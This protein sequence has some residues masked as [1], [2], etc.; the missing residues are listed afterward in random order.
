MSD[1]ETYRRDVRALARMWGVQASYTSAWGERVEQHPD[2]VVG[3]LGALG[4]D[5]ARP[6]SAADAVQARRASV[7]TRLLEPVSV[8]WGGRLE[9]VALR[10]A[11]RRRW[12]DPVTVTV[13]PEDDLGDEI[14]IR[15]HAV[16]DGAPTEGGMVA[17]SART[18]LELP[19]GYHRIAVEA[20]GEGAEGLLLAAPRRAP[21]PRG[22]HWGAFA[23]VYGL[24]GPQD[25]GVG[26]YTDLERL[27]AWLRSHGGEVMATVPMLAAFLDEPF[28]PSPYSP[29]SRLF[30]NELYV[31]VSRAPGSERNPEARRRIE[32]QRAWVDDLRRAEVVDARAVMSATREI[33]EPLAEACFR[34]GSPSMDR[35][36]AER[37]EV[38]DYARFRAEGDRRRTWWGDW[39]EAARRGDL[40]G[41]ARDDPAGRYHLFAQWVA[42]EQIAGMAARSRAEGGE[43]YLDL[44]LGVNGAGFDVWRHRDVFATGASAGSPPDPFFTGGQDWGFPPLHPERLRE[45]G[46]AYQIACLRHLLRSA[47][48]LR[49]DHV[50]SLHRLWWVPQG[51]EAT[52]GAYV[53]YPHDEWY[54]LVCLEAARADAVVVGEDLGTVPEEV[55]R[56]MRRHGLLSSYVLQY[57]AGAEDD[58]SSPREAPET[59]LASINTHDMP[60]WAGFWRGEDL[61]IARERGWMDDEEAVDARRARARVL[62]AMARLA[63]EGATGEPDMA[64]VLRRLLRHLAAGPASI[65]VATL[66]DLWLDPRPVNVPGTTDLPNWLVRLDRTLADI[67]DDQVL[68]EV[69]D[70]IHAARKETA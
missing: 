40:P 49:L 19:I 60:P 61:E 54:A 70:E 15:A 6:G 29:A 31:D 68:A 56:A 55:R 35:F 42:H 59:S 43:V 65:V 28:E 17:A 27:H 32:E 9:H 46:Y 39:P 22:R 4:V 30:W 5:A 13:R 8:A 21:S 52:A 38:L 26:T 10:L 14:R 11:A 44:P 7:D 48:I 37:P 47:S 20:D 2:A 50:M 1:R 23:P 24:R 16:A 45:K 51:A 34:E 58:G 62:A 12:S 69:L 53:R 33:L 67:A 41:D 36:I 64:D 57:E 63:S 3:V 66:Q 18:G 25:R